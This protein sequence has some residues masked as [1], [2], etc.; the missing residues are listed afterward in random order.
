[1]QILVYILFFFIGIQ[2]LNVSL[3][4]IFKQKLRFTELKKHDL[5]SVLI[6]A[7]NEVKNIGNI[8]NN[9]INQQY[10]NIE[11]LVFDD[12]S[13]DKT[14]EI[15]EKKMQFDSRIKLVKNP[16][17]EK[18]WLGKN[19]A[20]HNLAINAKGKYLLF[21]DADVSVKKHLINKTLAYVQ[22]YDLKLLSIFPT[23]KMKTFGENLTVPLMH[24][25]LLTLLPLIFVRIS[26]F[27]SHS[28]ANGQ[29]MLFDAETY[30]KYFP[31]K[32]FKNEKVEDIKIS[33]F[34]KAEKNKIACL[35]GTNDIE[36]RMYSGLNEAINGFSKNIVMFFGNSYFA[37][38]I[39][40]FVNTFG[41]VILIVYGNVELILLYSTFL[42]LLRILFSIVAKQNILYNIVLF[43]PQMVVMFLIIIKSIIYKFSK[44]LKWK[45]RYI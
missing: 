42:I 21:L 11:I 4:L 15:V 20:C 6:P 24:Y 10:N 3:N 13:E 17:L 22:K 38:L 7:R 40:W 35:T 37:T 27:K 29:F 2:F 26:P 16:K 12:E 25:I 33:R 14:A 18:N 23:Q 31:H 30:K 43:L 41:L 5:V 44:K 9:L 45:G 19:W 28:A 8:L 36:C 34:Y 39:F 32:K 1:M